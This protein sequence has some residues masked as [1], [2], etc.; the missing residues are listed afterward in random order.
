[1]FFGFISCNNSDTKE[2]QDQTKNEYVQ[3]LKPKKGLSYEEQIAELSNIFIMA[4]TSEVPEDILDITLASVTNKKLSD[5]KAFIYTYTTDVP[6]LVSDSYLK[7]PDEDLL[8]VMYKLHKVGEINYRKPNA[9]LI[10]IIEQYH[11]NVR[12]NDLLYNYYNI[13]FKR[14]NKSSVEAVYVQYNID[15]D[16]LNMISPEDK[17]ML[18]YTSMTFFGSRF[19]R[20]ARTDCDGARDFGDN[21]PLYEGK[22]FFNYV[23]PEYQYFDIVYGNKKKLVSI[24]DA[25]GRYADNALI[26]YNNCNK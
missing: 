22:S 4:Q 14:L 1:M 16:R 25:I 26:S 2:A 15:F 17:A 10:G 24:Q 13:L 3:Q 7:K 6:G 12:S 9:N 23:L 21:M 20:L 8:K 5:A 19:V 11:S 18:Y